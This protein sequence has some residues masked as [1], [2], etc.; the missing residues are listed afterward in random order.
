VRHDPLQI[1]LE[2][3]RDRDDGVALLQHFEDLEVIAHHEVGLAGQKQLRG[4]DLRAAHLERDIEPGFLIEPGRLGLIE[5]AVLGL[6]EPAR[7]KCH[8]VGGGC[9]GGRQRQAEDRGRRR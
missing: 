4:I 9:R 5:A 2:G 1:E 7:E 3:G 6:G 8:L